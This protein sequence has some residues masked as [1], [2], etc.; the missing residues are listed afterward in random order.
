MLLKAAM[1]AAAI[2]AV[3]WR[4]GWPVS[5]VRFGLYALAGAAMVAGPGLIW[6][7]AHVGLGALL[8][9][10]GLAAILVLLWRDPTVGDALHDMVKRRVARRR[11][12][13]AEHS[14]LR[15]EAVPHVRPRAS[16]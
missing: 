8:M 12:S 4:L 3:L 11:G 14:L 5:P 7:M 13:S 10:A 9:H 2:G 6:T 1:A 15:D 16:T